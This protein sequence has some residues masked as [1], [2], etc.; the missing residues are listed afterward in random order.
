MPIRLM[1]TWNVVNAEMENPSIMTRLLSAASRGKIT[2][3]LWAVL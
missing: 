1:T 3:K 2:L